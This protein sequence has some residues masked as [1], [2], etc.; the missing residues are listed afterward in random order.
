MNIDG[1]GES[2]VNQSSPKVGL[3]KDVADVYTLKDKRP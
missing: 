1:M 3:V 2:I